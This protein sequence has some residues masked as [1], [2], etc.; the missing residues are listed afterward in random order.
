MSK[1]RAESPNK[2]LS[3]EPLYQKVSL[4]ECQRS[5]SSSLVFIN[6]LTTFCPRKSDMKNNT[7]VVQEQEEEEISLSNFILSWIIEERQGEGTNSKEIQDHVT[8]EPGAE[9]VASVTESPSVVEE[10]HLEL[11]YIASTLLLFY[12]IALILKRHWNYSKKRSI[13]FANIKKN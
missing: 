1:F 11:F 9:N 13:F 10:D 3:A 7:D 2:S 5:S 8:E 4:N 12:M 6:F